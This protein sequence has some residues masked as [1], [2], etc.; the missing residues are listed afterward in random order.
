MQTKC[1]VSGHL[2]ACYLQ[3]HRNIL[4]FKFTLKDKSII[5]NKNIKKCHNMLYGLKAEW[6]SKHESKDVDFTG[7]LMESSWC[8]P[9]AA[10][11]K[12]LKG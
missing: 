4:Q 7:S 5:Y 3:L 8:I 6:V 11:T 2:I 12:C 10:N 9:R 1:N